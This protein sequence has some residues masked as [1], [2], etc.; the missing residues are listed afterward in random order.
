MDCDLCHIRKHWWVFSDDYKLTI[1]C[2]GKDFMK[3]VPD[4]K[5]YFDDVRNF[6]FL[7]M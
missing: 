6:G 1:T 3:M 7:H 5:I 4:L 2:R